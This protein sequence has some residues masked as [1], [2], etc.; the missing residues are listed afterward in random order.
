MKVTVDAKTKK[1]L[2][3]A[4]LGINGDE[5]LQSFLAVMLA[6]IPYT[7]ISR[8]IYLHPTVAEYLPTC[9][10]AQTHWGE[11]P[12][13]QH[14]NTTLNRDPREAV[15]PIAGLHNWHMN[16]TSTKACAHEALLGIDGGQ[17]GVC[18]AT[19]GCFGR[20]TVP[21]VNKKILRGLHAVVSR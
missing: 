7:A 21:S 11:C 4:I 14:S 10:N 16:G 18:A 9:S 3:G 13:L 12:P 17:C 15:A 8:E 1:I 20:A 19:A 5:V 6:A 2:E